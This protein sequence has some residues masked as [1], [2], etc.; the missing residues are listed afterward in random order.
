[1]SATKPRLR[2]DDTEV[3]KLTVCITYNILA[4]YIARRKLTNVDNNL[5]INKISLMNLKLCSCCETH[6]SADVLCTR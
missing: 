5:M 2:S 4:S 6:G 3:Y 1:M